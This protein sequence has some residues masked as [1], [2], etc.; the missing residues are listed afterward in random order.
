MLPTSNL[1]A[2]ANPLS[3]GTG[4]TP[5][6]EWTPMDTVRNWHVERTRGQHLSATIQT[7]M[8]KVRTTVNAC[9]VIDYRT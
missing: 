9:S 2:L 5:K 1:S 8:F 7:R 6:I 3:P 4:G